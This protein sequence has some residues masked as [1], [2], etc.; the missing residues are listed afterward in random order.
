MK[1]RE[2]LTNKIIMIFFVIS[3][4]CPELFCPKL[5]CM[6]TQNQNFKKNPQFGIRSLPKEEFEVNYSQANKPKKIAKKRKANQEIKETKE[7]NKEFKKPRKRRKLEPVII[8]A[9]CKKS[10]CL[11]EQLEEYKCGHCLHKA[12]I[13]EAIKKVGKCPGC[14]ENAIQINT[15]ENNILNTPQVN[16]FHV[17]PINDILDTG[18]IYQENICTLDSEN[19]INNE[20]L[21][22]KL[23]ESEYYKM[24]LPSYP[25]TL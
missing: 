3:L 8:C 6:L 20:D 19:S 15:I 23:P 4:F 18:I 7:I 13:I 11:K 24:L 17:N 2:L 1:L 5:F 22:P 25:C 14:L 12:C 10:I 21:L 16:Y 9:L